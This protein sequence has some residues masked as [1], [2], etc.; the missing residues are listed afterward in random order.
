MS[1]RVSCEVC[2]VSSIARLTAV[3]DSRWLRF[4]QA[5]ERLPGEEVG[6]YGGSVKLGTSGCAVVASSGRARDSLR[7]EDYCCA[8]KEISGFYPCPIVPRSAAA[9]II[10]HSI[11]DFITF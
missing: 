7:V 6:R 8:D 3:V 9:G 2:V 1:Q 10:L 11:E 4:L 5:V